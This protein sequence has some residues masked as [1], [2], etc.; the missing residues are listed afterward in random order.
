MNTKNAYIVHNPENPEDKTHYI[1]RSVKEL[2]RVELHKIF[3]QF[4]EGKTHVPSKFPR[5]I[6]VWD[7][8]PTEPR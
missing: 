5:D 4:M 7:D 1:I 6:I 2:N 8:G 3:N